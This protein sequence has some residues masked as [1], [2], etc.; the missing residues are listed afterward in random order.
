MN[1]VSR[2]FYWGSG[3]FFGMIIGPA[4]PDKIGSSLGAMFG[5]ILLGAFMDWVS[6]E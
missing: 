4:Q 3:V 1:P 5:F 6:E 2:I